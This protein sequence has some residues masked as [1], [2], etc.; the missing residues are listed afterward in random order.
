MWRPQLLVYL[1]SAERNG[2]CTATNRRQ[3]LS[4]ASQLKASRGLTIVASIHLE[5]ASIHAVPEGASL[6]SLMAAD[7]D[8]KR[9]IR[10]T[11]MHQCERMGVVGF[12][13]VVTGQSLLH[14]NP[15]LVSLMCIYV[16]V[17]P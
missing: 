13:E 4:F 5:E 2:T 9:S 17:S 1:H 8:K 14:C 15:H 3:L 10:R 16:C 11:L 6:A 12:V 7:Y